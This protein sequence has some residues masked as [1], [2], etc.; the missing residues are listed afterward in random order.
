MTD[1]AY[2]S[3]PVAERI[4]SRTELVSWVH[5][6]DEVQREY[7]L[8]V[9]GDSR[10]S[11]QLVRELMLSGK[12][13]RLI[14]FHICNVF[15]ERDI[16]H[17]LMHFL[18]VSVNPSK[19]LPEEIAV[20]YKKPIRRE[21]RG[22]A[23]K[24]EAFA[25]LNLESQLDSKLP[26]VNRRGFFVGPVL[27][28]PHVTTTGRFERAFIRSDR[29]QVLCD[30]GDPLGPPAEVAF[31]WTWNNE[32]VVVVSTKNEYIFYRVEGDGDDVELTRL[33]EPSHVHGL[34]E[35]MCTVWR[36][37]HVEDPIDWWMAERHQ[38]LI[39]A[40]ISTAFDMT[41]LGW[42]R[43]GQDR[44]FWYFFGNLKALG[45]GQRLELQRPITANTKGEGGTQQ[46]GVMDLDTSPANH[47]ETIMFRLRAVAAHYGIP[48]SSISLNLSADSKTS[49]LEVEIA[50]D[51]KSALRNEQIPFA[52]ARE[53]ESA[54]K[55]VMIA[56]SM[57][58]KTA[59]D[60][61][62]AD[63]VEAKLLCDWPEL[64]RIEQPK[65]KREHTKWLIS[66]GMISDVDIELDR[67]PEHRG[68]RKAAL[69]RILERQEEQAQLNV[70]RA[71]HNN[72]RDGE[73]AT[74]AE[75]NGA[76]GPIVRDGKPTPDEAEDE[77]DTQ[78]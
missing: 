11:L 33:E 65:D 44:K 17:Q 53:Q 46:T 50:H 58:H 14:A 39:D 7:T 32:S 5:R 22:A 15:N 67:N 66:R 34:D 21:L 64:N 71:E 31:P 13:K 29:F 28:W 54:R 20:C 8:P 55:A 9:W 1:L 70:Q 52:R 10:E 24:A 75:R 6:R 4:K 56:R 76:M 77:E 63:Y 72:P 61:P 36:W 42:I 47:I 35:Q 19:V 60:L 30:G 25:Q 49:A 37:E 38:S 57:G 68:N 18:D 48:G 2:I 23:K 62:T 41:K 40:T 3:D 51:L 45:K 26:K 43:K 74:A 73:M 16:I 69:T 27:E 12:H 78:E 59:K